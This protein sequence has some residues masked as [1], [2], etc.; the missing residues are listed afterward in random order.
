MGRKQNENKIKLARLD[1]D[2]NTG[3]RSTQTHWPVGLGQH[4]QPQKT[5]HTTMTE[6]TKR[7]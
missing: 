1:W 3:Y 5:S 2:I 4:T 7:L 6:E